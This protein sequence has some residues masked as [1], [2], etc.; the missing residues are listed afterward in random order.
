[1]SSYTCYHVY[2]HILSHIFT[3]NL[4]GDYGGGMHTQHYGYITYFAVLLIW[5]VMPTYIIV[6]FFRVRLPRYHGGVSLDL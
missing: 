4:Q 5:E 6:F 1:M 2:S 3:L